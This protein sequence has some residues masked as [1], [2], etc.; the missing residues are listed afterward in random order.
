VI[1]QALTADTFIFA[2]RI[3]TGA[4]AQILT[5]FAFHILFSFNFAIPISINIKYQNAKIKNKF[6][7]SNN[8]SQ[9]KSSSAYKP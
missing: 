9:T 6:Q 3:R 8:K 1:L 4:N 7:P 5:F 2:A